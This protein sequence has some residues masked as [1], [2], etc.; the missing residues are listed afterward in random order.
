ME[1]AAQDISPLNVAIPRRTCDRHW[2][3]LIKPLMRSRV[4]VILHI[5]SQHPTKMSVAENEHMVET[6]LTDRA[7]PAL[8]ERICVRRPE[9]RPND[10]HVLGPEYLIE[11]RRKLAVAVV[12]EKASWYNTILDLPAQLARLLCDPG[13][14]RLR[15]A[16]SQMDAAT[17]NLDEKQ[18]V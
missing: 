18:D 3:L 14:C 11:R 1:H 15:G 6:F 16:P 9:W 5:C 4:V 2:T 13:A 7:N 12:D 10:R 8:R 17:A